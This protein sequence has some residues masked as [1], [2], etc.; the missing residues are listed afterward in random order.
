[1]WRAEPN[2]LFAYLVQEGK[3]IFLGSSSLQELTAWLETSR[4]SPLIDKLYEDGFIQNP[5]SKL[6]I[7]ELKAY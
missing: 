6:E 2:G 5:T 7:S 3:R 1:M 4:P